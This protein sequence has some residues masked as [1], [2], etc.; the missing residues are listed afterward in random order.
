MIGQ[1]LPEAIVVAVS[2]FP[3]IGVV[4]L[5]STP[6]GK[7][8]AWAFLAGWLVGLAVL[9]ALVLLLADPAGATENG[10][11]ATWV[12]WLVL[13]L[14]AFLLIA[15]VRQFMSRPRGDEE[16]PQPKWMAMVDDFTR[17]K[18]LGLGFVLATANPKVLPVTLAAAAAIAT[19]GLSGGE[20]VVVMLVFMLIATIGIA[21]PI[22]ISY[23]AGDKSEQI[24]GDLH[25]WLAHNN[26]TIMAVILLV[27]GAKLLGDG[28][29]TIL[30]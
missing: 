5:L 1:I 15:G 10:G 20:S 11:P 24:L 30:A 28:I 9:G 27:I 4:L 8:K 6:Q 3:I 17:G 29:Q 25:H 18:S 7:A 16:P 22:A 14:G 2:P 21:T 23:L 19:A 26:A 13:A 12:G